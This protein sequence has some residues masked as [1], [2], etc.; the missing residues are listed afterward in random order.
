MNTVRKRRFGHFDKIRIQDTYFRYPEATAFGFSF[1]TVDGGLTEVF[2]DQKIEQLITEK[3]LRVDRDYYSQPRAIARGQSETELLAQLDPIE[4]GEIVFRLKC[5][6]QFLSLESARL[7]KRTD[8]SMQ[9]ALRLIHFN[10]VQL[11][12]DGTLKPDEGPADPGRRRAATKKRSDLPFEVPSSPGT[13]RTWLTR[14]EKAGGHP[15]GLR[16]RHYNSGNKEPRIDKIVLGLIDTFAVDYLDER[17]KTAK[18]CHKQLCAAINSLNKAETLI[19]AAWGLTP[20]DV[21]ASPGNGRPSVLKLPSAKTFNLRLAKLSNFEVD[22]KRL[23]LDDVKTT[24]RSS[25]AG[26]PVLEVLERVEIDEWEVHLH[27]VLVEAKVFE[28][29]SPELQRAVKRGRWHL[30]AAIDCASRA[31]LGMS[32]A[33]TACPENVMRTLEMSCR[34][35]SHIGM[36]AG[37]KTPWEIYGVGKMTCTDGGP[38]FISEIVRFAIA[39]LSS[40]HYLAPKGLPHFRARIERIFK[41]IDQKALATFTGRSFSNNSERGNYNAQKRATLTTGELADV[42][43]RFIV[44][45][46]H[47]DR[48]SGIGEETP[49]NC[50]NRLSMRYGLE[51]PP[52]PS[53]IRAIFGIDLPRT[54]GI[55][56]VRFVNIWYQSDDLQRWRRSE[57]DV[58][59]EI[60]VDPFD[61]GAISVKLDVDWIEV[62]SVF[63]FANG[64]AASVWISTCT[65]LREKFDAEYQINLPIVEAAIRAREAISRHAIERAGIG[66]ISI[67]QQQLE[68]AE[69]SL[70]LTLKGAIAE[71]DAPFDPTWDPLRDRKI[72][73]SEN[74][75]SRPVSAESLP[76]TITLE[77]TGNSTSPWKFED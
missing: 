13:L 43:V 26:L 66:P 77:G 62:R 52:H 33:P 6:E 65:D 48:H 74:T 35:K 8:E 27:T 70:S 37:A 64:L 72:Q 63:A 49:L 68:S 4:R 57:G 73:V 1:T 20:L 54:V 71:R 61:L 18:L 3:Q 2:T 44:D 53:Q 22:A 58:K 9:N 17:R 16:D 45:E 31:I 50:W 12:I 23:P 41:T 24:Y 39:D 40:C 51:V 25:Y 19:R 38:S 60:R 10:L 56:G 15:L 14:L 11:V 76:Q 46:Y 32:L 29:L 34:P 21:V 55:R 36:A 42:L 69:R 59:V 30:C 28:Q 47:N 75:A 67:T 5:C 7:V